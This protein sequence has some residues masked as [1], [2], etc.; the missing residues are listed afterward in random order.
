MTKLLL[1]AN[2][3]PLS[4]QINILQNFAANRFTIT[5]IDFVKGE[6]GGGVKRSS[7]NAG[8]IERIVN[9]TG[10]RC[11]IYSHISSGK[12]GEEML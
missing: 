6:G 12:Q 10:E 7:R 5:I 4:F 1:R 2:H 11:I 9:S 8:L 3:L